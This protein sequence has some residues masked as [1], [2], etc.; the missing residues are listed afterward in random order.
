MR[1]LRRL[2]LAAVLFTLVAPATL[3][4]QDVDLGKSTRVE[5]M[6]ALKERRA[7]HREARNQKLK[8]LRVEREARGFRRLQV[9][10]DEVRPATEKLAKELTWHDSLQSAQRVARRT[11]K[12]IV[13]VHALG[14]LTGVL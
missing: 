1:Q 13:W 11:G 10:G 9:E 2:S 14:E 7:L 8:E 3:T 5:R 12:P 6:A 4:A